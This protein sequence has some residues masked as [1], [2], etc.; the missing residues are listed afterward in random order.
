MVAALTMVPD[1]GQRIDVV[2]CG[3]TIGNLL[4]FVR[5]ENKPF[6]MLVE[7][8]GG[9]LFLIRRENTPRELIPDVTG[10]GHT[11][12]EA[13][14]TWDA[15]VR[16]ST[17]HQRVL[18]YRFGGLDF[19][20]RFQCDGYM[21]GEE[22]SDDNHEPPKPTRLDEGETIIDLA[23]AL[24]GSHVTAAAPGNG[25]KD[26]TVI[27]GGSLVQQ[28]SIFE[29]KTRSFRKK[30]AG[31]LEDTFGDQLPRLWVSQIP[32]LILAY[33]KHG[34]FE[35]INVRD[36]RSD[37][38]GWESNHVADLSRLAAVIHHIIN[39]VTTRPDNKLELRY[40]Q[41]GI[42]EVRGQLE[43]AGDALSVS[44]R[45]QWTETDTASREASPISQEYQSTSEGSSILTW[46]DEVEPDYTACS[47]EDCGYCGRCSY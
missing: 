18:S 35:D 30:E 13:Y 47:A 4:R 46:E 5:G 28:E 16:G 38:N 34:T 39:L 21:V 6:R 42:L 32:K 12:P 7:L 23:A 3:S 40:N 17:S 24:G 11:F 22:D 45:R 14:T 43:E 19:L 41:V 36:A 33:H 25:N 10:F 9:T 44:V 29:L 15:V 31:M 27:Q 26:V 1:L 20:V 2:A 8:V 37:V